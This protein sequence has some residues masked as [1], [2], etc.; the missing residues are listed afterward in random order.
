MM[1]IV[2]IAAV[3]NNGVI[4]SQGAMPWHLPT[5][6]KRFRAL[7]IGHP[8]IMG[9][10]T[11]RSLGGPLKA[12]LNIVLTRS[13]RLEEN[14]FVFAHSL[15]KA[16]DYATATHAR[17]CFVIGGGEVYKL[18]LPIADRVELTQIRAAFR[19]DTFFPALGPDWTEQ[20][21]EAPLTE[22]GVTYQFTTLRKA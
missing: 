3:A 9:H 16:L 15:P 5:D 2:L 14:G 13:G 11:A 7:T 18:A 10:K 21:F 4:G 19:G 8:V 17:R 12:R 1:E 20:I 6:L 22:C